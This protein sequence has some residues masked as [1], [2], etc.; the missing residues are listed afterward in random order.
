[1]AGYGK[2][3][4]G[5]LGAEQS[6]TSSALGDRNAGSSPA[7]ATYK[8]LTLDAVLSEARAKNQ[9]RPRPTFEE[10]Y[11]SLESSLLAQER[12]TTHPGKEG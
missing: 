11:R 8:P 9:L 1:M 4:T 12:A 3:Q 2:W 5:D 7:P 10:A 6:A